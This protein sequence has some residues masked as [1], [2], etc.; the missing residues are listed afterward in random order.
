MVTLGNTLRPSYGCMCKYTV[1]LFVSDDGSLHI[2]VKPLSETV[3]NYCQ[4]NI[5]NMYDFCNW[6][7]FIQ[8]NAFK[9]TVCKIA[10]ILSRLLCQHS[11][12]S[13]VYT[14]QSKIHFV[15]NDTSAIWFTFLKLF[16]T[17]KWIINQRWFRWYAFHIPHVITY[18]CVD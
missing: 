3:L 15:K 10:P 16:M 5:F 7:C 18:P 1:I 8:Q 6:K 13:K 17:V 4:V 14:L 2:G 11:E 9:N 12:A